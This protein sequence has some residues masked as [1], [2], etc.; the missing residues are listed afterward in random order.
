MLPPT[1]LGS[2]NGT[3]ILLLHGFDSSALE[4]R[5]LLPLLAKAGFAP[6]AVDAAGWVRP[7][8]RPFNNNSFSLAGRASRG[9]G[10]GEFRRSAAPFLP[11]LAK[12][13]FSPYAVDAA[14]WVRPPKTVD[15]S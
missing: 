6:Y 15:K 5:R 3:P 4:F 2:E 13:G 12:A 14:G 1:P 9:G 11:L 10:R 8:P 7:P